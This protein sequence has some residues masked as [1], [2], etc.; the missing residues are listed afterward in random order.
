MMSTFDS[1]FPIK[2]CFVCVLLLK[3]TKSEHR[4][5]QRY[6]ENRTC[7]SIL[8]KAAYFLRAVFNY[9]D[10]CMRWGNSREMPKRKNRPRASYL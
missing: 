4:Q 10:I 5:F 9:N 1:P 2:K 8:E 7:L 3:L 6:G